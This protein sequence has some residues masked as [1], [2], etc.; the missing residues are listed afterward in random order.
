MPLT[1]VTQGLSAQA[2]CTAALH[3]R[4]AFRS[5]SD[6]IVLSDAEREH[7]IAT[8]TDIVGCGWLSRDLRR[9]AFWLLSDLIAQRSPEQV[10][11]MEVAKGLRP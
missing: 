3:L 6:G 9:V 4:P 8:V 2:A 7:C 10:R 1:Q 11:R 5:G